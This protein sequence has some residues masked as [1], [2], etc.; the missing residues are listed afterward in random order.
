MEELLQP[1]S[2]DDWRKAK[3]GHF[4]EVRALLPGSVGVAESVLSAFVDLQ[5]AAQPVNPNDDRVLL[6]PMVLCSHRGLL[7]S[8][9]LLLEGQFLEAFA[10][11]RPTAELAGHALRMSRDAKLVR[12]W[13]K[14]DEDEG[15]FNKAFKPHLPKD[16]ALT[17]GLYDLWDMASDTGMHAN[18]KLILFHF[19]AGKRELDMRYFPMK[20]PTLQRFFIYFINN[21]ASILKIYAV[22]LGSYFGKDFMPVVR[23]ALDKAQD[24]VNS[25]SRHI[26]QQSKAEAEAEAAERATKSGGGPK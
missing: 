8:M 5:V 24:H 6:V 26:I 11:F 10:I 20:V 15:S 17:K 19:E 22:G 25:Y 16:D 4:D 1:R 14:R 13:L 21:S 23:G 7:N 12:V 18:A 9:Q 2:F 3:H